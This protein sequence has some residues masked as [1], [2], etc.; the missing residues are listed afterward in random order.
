[1]AENA[2]T[3]KRVTMTSIVA[4]GIDADGVQLFNQHEA[5]DYVREDFLDAYVANAKANWQQVIVS[6]D[7]DAGPG[8][9]EGATHVPA[10]LS[11]PLAG[12][13]FAATA[14]AVAIADAAAPVY[15]YPSTPEGI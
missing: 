15:D 12:Q 2:V 11:H 8:G 13:T 9:Y 1:M 4:A 14:P 5:V 10:E 6:D 3:K 7:Y